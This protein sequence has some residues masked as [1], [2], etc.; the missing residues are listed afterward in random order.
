MQDSQGRNKMV[1]EAFSDNDSVR[2]DKD[3]LIA[4]IATAFAGVSRGEGTSLHEAEEMDCHGS[5]AELAAARKLDVDTRWQEVPGDWIESF[6]SAYSFL[7]A[8]GLRYYLPATMIWTLKGEREL[9]S[10]TGCNIEFIL[11]NPH[12]NVRILSQLLRLLTLGQRRAVARW[13]SYR[14]ATRPYK[15]REAMKQFRKSA[16]GRYV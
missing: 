15:P 2:V 5:P 9:L 3:A 14:A 12:Q 10:A 8:T 13:L 7:D 11:S 4:E 6:S 1:E 16:W